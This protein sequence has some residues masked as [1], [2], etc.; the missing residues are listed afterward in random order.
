MAHRYESIREL[1]DEK[2]GEK[3]VMEM[4]IEKYMEPRPFRK[5]GP[6]GEE[7]I[8]ETTIG[9]VC[10]EREACLP[11]RGK[12]LEAVPE[13]YME[14]TPF[15]EPGDSIGEERCARQYPT[16]LANRSNRV[17]VKNVY[18]GVLFEFTPMSN[19]ARFLGATRKNMTFGILDEVARVFCV[20]QDKFVFEY[21]G[22]ERP[23]GYDVE[24]KVLGGFVEVVWGS[25]LRERFDSYLSVAIHLGLLIW[26]IM[27]EEDRWRDKKLAKTYTIGKKYC[28]LEFNGERRQMDYGKG[29]V[30]HWKGIYVGDWEKVRKVMITQGNPQPI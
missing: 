25:G 21:D 3:R 28:T 29:I 14:P 9:Y 18:T 11:K 6:W 19:S 16:G 23:S 5:L 24:E 8:E 12:R 2:N 7:E 22:V 4:S 26:H 27:E 1:D 13:T 30:S 20:G 15:G 10:N 17:R